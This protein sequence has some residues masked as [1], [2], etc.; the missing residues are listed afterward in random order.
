MLSNRA[1]S[2]RTET[3]DKP[4]DA[5]VGLK[6][7][8]V[9]R[10]ADMLVL[11]FGDVRKHESGSGTVGAYALH[12]QCPWRFAGPSGIVTG[13]SDLSD[14]AGPGQRPESW[15][16]EDGFSLQDKILDHFIGSYDVSTGSWFNERNRFIVTEV[17]LSIYGDVRIALTH[18]HEI[19]VFPDGNERGGEAWRFFACGGGGHLVFPEERGQ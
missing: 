13:R 9:R 10:V 6:L 1:K 19:F 15:T 17:S 14:Y 18:G 4:L 7:S 16:Y 8:I 5:L 11:H 3:E 2:P 12:V